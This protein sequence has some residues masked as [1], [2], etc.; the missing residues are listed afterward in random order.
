MIFSRPLSW[1]FLLTWGVSVADQ[2]VYL[3]RPS[4]GTTAEPFFE[5]ATVTADIGEQIHFIAL[6]PNALT[7]NQVIRGVL[8]V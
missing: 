2:I 7:P 1:T 6:F 5:P 8:T 4:P 3:N